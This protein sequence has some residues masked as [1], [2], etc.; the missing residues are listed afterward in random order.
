[1]F[2]NHG[3]LFLAT[4]ACSIENVAAF[5]PST[6]AKSITRN[7]NNGNDNYSM[8]STA[9]ISQLSSPFTRKMVNGA[10][11]ASFDE[12]W[13]PLTDNEK[14]CK[15]ILEEGTGGI[16]VQGSTVELEYT[17][18]LLGEADWTTQ[19]VTECWLSQLQ[20]L[21]HLKSAFVQ[22]DI[23]GSKLMDTSYFTE[24][25]CLEQ[26][27]LSNKIQAKKLVM[28]AKRLA[29]QQ[30]DIPP[31]MLFDSSSERGK[32]FSFILG[33]GKAIKAVDLAA[34][35]MKVGEKSKV[36]CRADYA[37]GSEGLRTSKGDVLVPPFANLCFELKLVRSET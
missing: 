33:N 34:G 12:K 29:K 25:F 9:V 20:G 28:A 30:E 19:D 37:Y 23:D 11:S 21:D 35:T 16:P 14:V 8:K 32:N 36:V 31:G 17:G 24:E 10:E 15:L 5:T 4:S 18:T 2:L 7:L 1:M 22:N 6:I 3:L 26:L 27:G 13:I